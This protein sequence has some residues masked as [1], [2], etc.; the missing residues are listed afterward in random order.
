ME[1]SLREFKEKFY[2]V[3]LDIHWKHWTALGVASHVKP[4][5]TR[6]I[7]LEPL[8]IS[9]LTIGLKDKRL[10]SSSIEW[11]IKNG[12]WINL[13]RLKRIVKVFSERLPELKAP[14]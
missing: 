9:T 4:E 7:D 8:I 2:K 1:A 6:I 3:L 14:P 13:S 5:K 12:E 11:L 10:L